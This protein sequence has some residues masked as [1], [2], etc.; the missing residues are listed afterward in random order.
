MG[1]LCNIK[2][3]RYSSG[4]RADA[5]NKTGHVTHLTFLGLF[6]LRTTKL[7]AHLPFPPQ[8]ALPAS[9]SSKHARISKRTTCFSPANTAD[10]TSQTGHDTYFKL[11]RL[12]P[13]LAKNLNAYVR[14]TLRTICS[15]F[16][17]RQRSHTRPT[18][19]LPVQQASATVSIEDVRHSAFRHSLP[20]SA[21]NAH[22]RLPFCL[23]TVRSVTYFQK[24]TR[25]RPSYYPSAQQ[26]KTTIH[27]KQVSQF[28]SYHLLP[29]SVPKSLR[30]LI[31]SFPNPTF[32]FVLSQG[33][34]RTAH[35]LRIF[36]VSEHQKQHKKLQLLR[37]SRPCF[38]V[39]TKCSCSLIFSFLNHTS[40]LILPQA[41]P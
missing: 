26:A 12:S 18:C 30:S 29:P 6:L 10:I 7:Y 32:C 40:W 19:Y 34:R 24:H 20:S 15:S 33:H 22:A 39:S 1:E 3:A 31:S 5:T 11:L 27:I 23:Q 17:C 8:T 9:H 36:S 21:A 2:P 4:H 25:T 28:A 38:V 35:L 37:I 14:L 13:S 16:Q 41:H